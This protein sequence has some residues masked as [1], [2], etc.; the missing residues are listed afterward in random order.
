MQLP[1]AASVTYPSSYGGSVCQ[2]VESR[3]IEKRPQFQC[4]VEENLQI[5]AT[6]HQTTRNL[7]LYPGASRIP[8]CKFEV[9]F[10]KFHEENRC[11][12]TKTKDPNNDIVILHHSIP[13]S[14]RCLYGNTKPP[15]LYKFVRD[16]TLPCLFHLTSNRKTKASSFDQDLHMILPAIVKYVT[17]PQTSAYHVLVS[18]TMIVY[19]P[20]AL[21]MALSYSFLPPESG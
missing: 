18:K 15:R 20:P 17:L 14:S 3:L 11:D 21:S 13:A 2:M 5:R 9:Q 8:A 16:S 6:S 4:E 19:I 7:Y 1:A 12:L 10:Y